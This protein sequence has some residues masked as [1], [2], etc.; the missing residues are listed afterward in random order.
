MIIDVST[1]GSA[2]ELGGAMRHRGSSDRGPGAQ[3]PEIFW[4]LSVQNTRRSNLALAGRR[5]NHIFT[6]SYNKFSR[7]TVYEHITL[8]REFE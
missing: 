1:A 3:S 7:L 4:S 8:T 5:F 2:S 6:D